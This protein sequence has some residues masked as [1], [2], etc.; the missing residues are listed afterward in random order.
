MLLQ[1]PVNL[2]PF[3]QGENFCLKYFRAGQLLYD[4]Y[5]LLRTVMRVKVEYRNAFFFCKEW[6][7]ENKNCYKSNAGNDFFSHKEAPFMNLWNYI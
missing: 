6:H 4:I 3:N 5:Q 1:Q 2:A 7:R